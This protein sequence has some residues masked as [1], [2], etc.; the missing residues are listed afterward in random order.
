MRRQGAGECE[1][2]RARRLRLQRSARSAA[3]TG[4]TPLSSEERQQEI[5]EASSAPGISRHHWG[6]DVDVMDP[7]MD[8]AQW[9]VGGKFAGPWSWMARNASSYGFIQSF[10]AESTLPVR[11]YMEERWHW[12]YFPIAQA[13]LDFARAHQAELDVELRF[14]W[15][16]TPGRYAFISRHWR[17]YMFNVNQKG[18]F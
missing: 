15:S 9:N 7:R 2:C 16:A 14:Q 4:F 5:L 6:T 3:P 17:D 12:S 11:G 18:G 10:T 13:L 8:P 1:E